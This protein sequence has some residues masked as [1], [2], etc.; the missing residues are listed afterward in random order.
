MLR[1]SRKNGRLCLAWLNNL[2]LVVIVTGALCFSPALPAAAADTSLGPAA[3]RSGRGWPTW[4]VDGD[5]RATL[6]DLVVL[7]LVSSGTVT[8]GNAPCLSPIHGDLNGNTVLD[9]ADC[10]LMARRMS[11]DPQEPP[12]CSCYESLEEEFAPVQI[13]GSGLPP[14]SGDHSWSRPAAYVYLV[15]FSGV[16]GSPAAHEGVDYVHGNSA[17]AAVPVQAASEG[18][19]VY[20]RLGCPQSSLFSPNVSLRECGAGWGNHVIVHHGGGIY[21]RYAHLVPGSVTVRT[22]DVVRRGQ[23][24]GIMGNAG[25]SQLRHLH[26][27]LGSEDGLLDPCAPA[28]SLDRVYDAELLCLAPGLAEINPRLIPSK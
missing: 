27:E 5:G 26:F 19:V 1:D 20:V 10:S 8:P 6:C 2:I 24:V 4:D 22:G 21:T 16:P 17:V 3:N 18:T 14:G 7:N 28:P 12:P 23:V 15:A 9:T 11:G 25:R 13:A